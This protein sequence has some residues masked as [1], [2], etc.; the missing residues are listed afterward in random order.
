MSDEH[1]KRIQQR[2]EEEYAALDDPVV[3][4]QLQLDRMWQRELDARAAARSRVEG[5]GSVCAE[6]GIYDPLARFESEF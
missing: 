4:G 3:K 6:A 5:P 2:L 1:H